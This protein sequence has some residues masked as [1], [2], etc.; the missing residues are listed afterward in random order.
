[1][2][3][4]SGKRPTA[5]PRVQ[6]VS[7]WY[8]VVEGGLFVLALSLGM[9]TPF[10]VFGFEGVQTPHAGIAATVLLLV[11]VVV[12][13]ST[14]A[15]AV[16]LVLDSRALATAPGDWPPNPLAYAF[17]VVAAAPLAAVHYLARRRWHV[18][19][20]RARSNWWLLLPLGLVGAP[21]LTVVAVGLPLYTAVV[22]V[23]TAGIL[24]A[25][26]PVGIYL[27]TCHVHW[28]T[29]G[30]KHY[31]TGTLLLAALVGLVLPPFLYVAAFIHLG[32]RYTAVGW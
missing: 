11:P 18:P 6:S 15:I 23:V 16:G 22:A 32:R 3:D 14:V 19:M 21:L 5:A 7:N 26:V 25:G 30:W 27:D 9:V 1:M 17:A 13:V 31:G 8:R 4:Q 28:V 2:I 20:P 10:W 12:V 24:A 29:G